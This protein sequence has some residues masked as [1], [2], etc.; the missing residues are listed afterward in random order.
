MLVDGIIVFWSLKSRKRLERVLIYICELKMMLKCTLMLLVMT[1]MKSWKKAATK[2]DL[3]AISLRDNTNKLMIKSNY[4]W[5]LSRPRVA[6]KPA[7]P[8]K[9]QSTWLCAISV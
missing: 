5:K 7:K 2:L 8:R 4:I 9:R 6:K 3:Q 1:L